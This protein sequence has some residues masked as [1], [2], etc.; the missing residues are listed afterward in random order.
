M[1]NTEPTTGS[2]SELTSRNQWVCWKRGK[3]KE[4]GRFE[5]IPCFADFPP[6]DLN[7]Q[8]PS[9][10]LSYKDALWAA[11]FFWEIEGIGF[12][13]TKEDPYCFLDLDNCMDR[14][15]GW[16]A[17]WA[18]RLVDRLDSFAYVTPSG[19]GI[20][21]VVRGELADGGG[22]YMYRDEEG[23]HV[24][25]AYDSGQMLTFTHRIL[26]APIREAQEVLDSLSKMSAT[27]PRKGLGYDFS[28]RDLEGDLD[29]IR[30]E[31]KR[32][33]VAHELSP[34]PI[35][36]GLR[37]STLISIGAHLLMDGR[38]EEW[39]R[40]FL[41]KINSTL[42]YNK[43]GEL[44]GLNEDE[45]EEVFDAN[46]KLKPKISSKEVHEYLDLV[47]DFLTLIRPRMKG[48]YNT[49]WSFL[50]ALEIQGRKY[51][52]VVNEDEIRIDG[53]RLTLQGLSRIASSRTLDLKISRLKSGE[54]LKTGKDK[55]DRTGH[56]ILNVR[57][58]LSGSYFNLSQAEIESMQED[59]KVIGCINNSHYLTILT[60]PF[61]TRQYGNAKGSLYAAIASLGG[62]G[63]TGE[64][65]LRMGRVDEN[66]K[67]KCGS[68]SGLLRSC[69]QEDGTLKNP[70]RGYWCF[71]EDFEDTLYRARVGAGEFDRDTSFRKHKEDKRALF[72]E[73]RR[74][75]FD[76]AA[77][78]RE[79]FN[80]MLLE[81][82]KADPR[83][84]R[85]LS[86]VGASKPMV[87]LDRYFV[88]GK[89]VTGIVGEER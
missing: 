60:H 41:P 83:L 71:S 87:V 39:W 47:R 3:T 49:D 55:R 43:N 13:P 12:V 14:K 48:A 86:T 31:V 57:T 78:Q 38:S 51:G 77:K 62:G 44:E 74:D 65:A 22:H 68:I 37:K 25:E 5:K 4:D 82:E 76:E 16:Y 85:Q 84:A 27:S 2:V 45:L 17:D 35:G 64:I 18:V 15:A 1:T 40:E 52:S 54:I 11:N 7:A 56:F 19:K 75:Y 42:L 73:C 88:E 69:E 61:W 66:G 21:I 67:P 81:L 63:R 9:N 33:L 6:Y 53:S 79:L 28:E 26:D 20:R 24:L 80:H 89:R 70:R 36:E 58:L 23:D 72:R 34:E 10:H 46:L 8:D 32:T 30:R 50:K 29:E 59:S